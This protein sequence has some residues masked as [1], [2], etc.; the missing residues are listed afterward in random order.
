MFFKKI[1]DW[2][3]RTFRISKPS[4]EKIPK[5]I[6]GSH[7]CALQ[8]LHV[9]CP[10]I[11]VKSMRNSFNLCCDHWP[12]QGVTNKEFNISIN[13]LEVRNRFQYCDDDSIVLN[14]LLQKKN[15]IFIA[16]IY[17]HFTVIHKGRII[18]DYTNY[19]SNQ[20]VYCY[21]HLISGA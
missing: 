14:H 10:E 1:I 17:G 20:K 16:L 21:W 2:F 4:Y 12:H 19:D 9:V 8:A 18:D 11:S 3:F 13:H 6:Q 5:E 7:D 15:A